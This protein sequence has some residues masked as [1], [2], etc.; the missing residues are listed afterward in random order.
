MRVAEVTVMSKRLA[1]TTQEAAALLGISDA[2]IRQEVA[3]ERIPS[4]RVAR[5]ILIPAAAL[6]ALTGG[7]TAGGVQG[8]M[9]GGSGTRRRGECACSH[10]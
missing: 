10:R 8:G 2:T 9:S 5:R 1:Y 6:T 3:A 7:A 4:C